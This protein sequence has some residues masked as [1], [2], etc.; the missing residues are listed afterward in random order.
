VEGEFVHSMA[1]F[2]TLRAAGDVQDGAQ[3][4]GRGEFFNDI[5][6]VVLENCA[7]LDTLYKRTLVHGRVFKTHELDVTYPATGPARFT[8][9]AK[10]V[11]NAAAP[12]QRDEPVERPRALGLGRPR[13]AAQ[14]GG[15]Q[16][17]RPKAEYALLV[18]GQGGISR[19]G[20]GHASMTSWLRQQLPSAYVFLAAR[21][22]DE[23]D[24]QRLMLSATAINQVFDHVGVFCFGPVDDSQPTTY[25]VIPV[26]TSAYDLG[27][28]LQEA[29]R[30]LR[31]IHASLRDEL[32][33]A[34]PEDD[35]P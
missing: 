21:C 10:G 17:H 2:D 6:A 15:V 12:W 32:Q 9:E 20:P 30:D 8:L 5:L 34:E 7:G 31:A 29:C 4:N 23:A 22:V 25:K 19:T 24:R 27:H 35:R 26:Q 33:I 28:V 3:R 18:A 14:G 13:Q 16:G 11:G 1:E